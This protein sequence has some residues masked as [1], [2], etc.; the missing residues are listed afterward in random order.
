MK[1]YM[2]VD[3]LEAYQKL[4]RVHI[5]ISDLSHQW[6]NEEKYEIG[7]QIRRCSNSSPQNSPE[8]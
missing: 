4:C 2:D 5:E 8:E 6:P 3:D 1:S 7:S